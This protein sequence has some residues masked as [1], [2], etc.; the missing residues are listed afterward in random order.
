MIEERKWADIAHDIA[1]LAVPSKGGTTYTAHDIAQAHHITD[2]PLLSN[3]KLI[4][5]IL[6]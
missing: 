4:F 5:F 1:M 6:G 3:K 2:T